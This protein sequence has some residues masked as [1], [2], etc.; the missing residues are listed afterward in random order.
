MYMQLLVLPSSS[1]RHSSSRQEHNYHSSHQTEELPRT[2][3]H[4]LI[5]Y[6]HYLYFSIL[7]EEIGRLCEKE[8]VNNVTSQNEI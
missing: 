7:A 1:Q 6:G 5:R 2:D 4:I 3:R 8:P